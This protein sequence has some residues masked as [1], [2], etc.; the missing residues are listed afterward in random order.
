MSAQMYQSGI[1]GEGDGITFYKEAEKSSFRFFLVG[2]FDIDLIGD[3]ARS[4]D[5]GYPR[6][7]S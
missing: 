1:S 6:P 3:Q 7:F 4:R 2:L 5:G